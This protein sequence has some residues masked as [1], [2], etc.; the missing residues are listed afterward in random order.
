MPSLFLFLCKLWTDWMLQTMNAAGIDSI[1]MMNP[2][3]VSLHKKNNKTQITKCSTVTGADFSSCH[4]LM[5]GPVGTS[6][7]SSP[8]RRVESTLHL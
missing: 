4:E 8:Q 2:F 5:P 1:L 7:R 6:W 3:N